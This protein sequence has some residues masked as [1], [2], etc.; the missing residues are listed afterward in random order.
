MPPTYHR[1]EIKAQK[2]LATDKSPPAPVNAA[3]QNISALKQ[4]PVDRLGALTLFTTILLY[5]AATASAT[6]AATADHPHTCARLT[7]KRRSGRTSP[8]GSRSLPPP[9]CLLPSLPANACPPC[10]HGCNICANRS[11]AFFFCSGTEGLFPAI[12]P[13][14][15]FEMGGK[16]CGVGS[17]HPGC[18]P[19]AT[20]A[21]LVYV[22]GHRGP[23]HISDTYKSSFR[24][25]Y[26]FPYY[27]I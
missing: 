9:P 10:W 18:S 25:V 20:D 13:M 14:G 7:A 26:L 23:G 17:P 22:S 19:G 3:P 12:R 11:Q 1:E 8:G 5:L 16:V 15:A 24:L 21:S 4:K 27:R 6:V 2:L